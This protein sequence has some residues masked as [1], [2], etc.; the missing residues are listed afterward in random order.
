[1]TP[2]ERVILR[3]V[4]ASPDYAARVLPRFEPSW[5]ESEA[6]AGLLFDLMKEHYT[7]TGTPPELPLLDLA[8]TRLS[9]KHQL[10]THLQETLEK[11]VGELKATE[12]LTSDEA[13]EQETRGF[14]H[15]H[16]L[17]VPDTRSPGIGLRL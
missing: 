11:A 6:T 15:R 13:I 2:V 17:L 12:P 8:V 10:K 1:M 16:V 3:Q 9:A 5:F 4:L 7:T 14:L